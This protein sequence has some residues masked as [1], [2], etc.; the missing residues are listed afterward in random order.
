MTDGRY[1]WSYTY[2]ANGMRIGRGNGVT[3]YTYVYS[4]TQLIEMTSGWDKLLFTY[5]AEGRP[6]TVEYIGT[7]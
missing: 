3:N 1:I 5:D 7:L 6:L 4:G 2:D